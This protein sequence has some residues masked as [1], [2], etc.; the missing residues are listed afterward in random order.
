MNAG[1][2]TRNVP[3]WEPSSRNLE[4][5]AL[6]QG[7]YAVAAWR[8]VY[9][10]LY[11]E[12]TSMWGHWISDLIAIRPKQRFDRAHDMPAFDNGR[13]QN[14]FTFG[15]NVMVRC[16]TAFQLQKTRRPR[17]DAL[18]RLVNKP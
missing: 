8:S 11:S 5:S 14:Q 13:K 2:G 18:L 1:V 10:T 4:H 15:M 9:K 6:E 17:W 3:R 12:H 16:Q 7:V